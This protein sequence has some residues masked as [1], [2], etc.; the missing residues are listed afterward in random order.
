MHFAANLFSKTAT[1][2]FKFASQPRPYSENFHLNNFFVAIRVDQSFSARLVLER[3]RPPVKNK[4][5]ES[6]Q[7]RGAQA[8]TLFQYFIQCTPA[9][10]TRV[11]IN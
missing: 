9:G 10:V 11:Y 5:R 6:A 8:C 2:S 3:A 1:A 7:V 4:H